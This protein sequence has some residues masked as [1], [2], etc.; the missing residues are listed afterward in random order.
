[1]LLSKW[2]KCSGTCRLVR[3]RQRGPDRPA[4]YR[5]PIAWRLMP[6]AAPL[7]RGSVDSIF[8]LLFRHPFRANRDRTR[9]DCIRHLQKMDISVR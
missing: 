5:P 9:T 2:N 1:V 8:S 3:A 4:S 6:T 7:T